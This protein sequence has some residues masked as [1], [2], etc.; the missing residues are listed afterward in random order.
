VKSKWFSPRAILL[1]LTLIAW[2]SGCVA[3][4]W[5][6]IARA[7]DGNA[8]SYLYAIEWPIFAIAGVLGWYA[9][10]NIEKVTEAQEQAR[11][12]YEEKM[13]QEAQ[14]ARVV[15]EESP[16]LAAYN[17]HLAALAK[18]PRKKLWGH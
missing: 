16:E 1:H 6:Q 9:L 2:V 7:A 13:R 12:E 10:L 17:N 4:A 5:W 18:Q 14:Q 3:A 11:R 15:D 8:L